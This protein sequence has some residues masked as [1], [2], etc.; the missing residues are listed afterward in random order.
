MRGC[1]WRGGSVGGWVDVGVG[2]GVGVCAVCAVWLYID[3]E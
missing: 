2:V 3:V 1:G